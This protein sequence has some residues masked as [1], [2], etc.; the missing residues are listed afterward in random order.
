MATVLVAGCGYVGTALAVA[1][2]ADGHD[3]FGLRRDPSGLPEGIRPLA[4][5]LSSRAPLVLPADVDCAVYCVGAK[6]GT[7]EAYRAAYVDGL[8]KL[9][10]AL[11]AQRTPPRRVLFTSSTSVYAQRDGEWVDEDS[12]TEPARFSGRIL[13]EGES[14]LASSGLPATVVR[15]GGIYGPGRTSLLAR[16]AR[17]EVTRAPGP[18]Q[19]TNRIHRDDAA[20]VLRFLLFGLAGAVRPVYLGVDCEPAAQADVYAFLAEALGVPEPA[21]AAEAPANSARRP[22]S[23]RCSNARL[24]AAGYAF[25]YPSFREG[26]QELVEAYSASSR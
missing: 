26:Y 11:A 7:E 18:P 23:K 19:Y 5:D 22:G 13:L 20:G 6:A 3:V 16:V 15:L 8:D 25:R 1:L 24:L 2:R 12:E 4:F 9:L 21:L 17:G 14:H 10:D